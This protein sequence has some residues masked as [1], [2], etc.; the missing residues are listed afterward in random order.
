MSKAINTQTVLV[1]GAGRGLGA[2]IATAFAREGAAVVI[3][4]R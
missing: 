2:A 1:T 4:Y 3:N